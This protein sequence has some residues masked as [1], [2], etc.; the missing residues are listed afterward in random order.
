MVGRKRCKT[1][2]K[3]KG[4]EMGKPTQ[5]TYSKG[6]DASVKVQEQPP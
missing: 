2:E 6:R 3:N 1:K 5:I 4:K